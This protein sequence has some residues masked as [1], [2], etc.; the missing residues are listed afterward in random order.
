MQEKE[1]KSLF[2]QHYSILCAFANKYVADMETARDIVQQVYINLWD[3]W[4]RLDHEISLKPYLFRAVTNRCLNHLRSEKKIV[5]VELPADEVGVQ[6]FLEETDFLETQELKSKISRSI[7][8]PPEKCRAIFL[9]SRNQEKSYK[10]IAAALNVSVKAVEAQ[11]T[12]ALKLLRED[13]SDYLVIILITKLGYEVIL[14][15]IG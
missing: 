7:E 6:S 15:C 1:F 4:G 9:M 3:N 14:V 13:L 10:E 2:D 11:M 12:K 8:K 5:H